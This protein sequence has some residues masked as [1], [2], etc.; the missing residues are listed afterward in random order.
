VLGTSPM[1][2]SGEC[3]SSWWIPPLNHLQLRPLDSL[4]RPCPAQSLRTLE[5]V[6]PFP[7]SSLPTLPP[8]CH[9]YHRPHARTRVLLLSIRAPSS[10]APFDPRVDSE[11]NAQLPSN[12]RSY[13]FVEFRS[14]RDAEDAYYDM[15]VLYP[16][17]LFVTLSYGFLSQARSHVRG[18]S[19]RH[20]G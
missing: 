12:Y 15:L 9:P 1:S 16:L 17:F 2:L 14:T 19:P 4:R 5:P 8:Q 10:S 20:P 13:A 6:G 18:F 3:A 11:T 7:P